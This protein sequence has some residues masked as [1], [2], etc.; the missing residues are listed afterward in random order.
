M[1]TTPWSAE[2]VEAWITSMEEREILLVLRT[3]QS[4]I[5]GWGAIKSYSARAG[6]RTTG[7]IS[8]YLDPQDCGKGLGCPLMK[9][10]I[11]HAQDAG[12]HH[13]VAKTFASNT[14]SR[15][16][17]ETHGFELVGIQKEVGQISGKWQDIAIYQLI[18]SKS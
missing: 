16:F 2:T 7:E 11:H 15:Q 5:H 6:Y 10:L 1:D 17:H 18:L 9:A 13:I 3:P 12:I 8:L 4:T 14:H